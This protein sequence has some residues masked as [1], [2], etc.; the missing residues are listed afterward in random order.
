MVGGP[1]GMKGL[2]WDKRLEDDRRWRG[3]RVPGLE[4]GQ[5]GERGG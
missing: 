1:K 4:A 3:Q 2:E 5:A